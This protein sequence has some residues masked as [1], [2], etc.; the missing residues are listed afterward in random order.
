MTRW[1]DLRQ[2]L[3]Y[4]QQ[5]PQHSFQALQVES[6]GAIGF[7]LGRV[8]VDFHEHTIYARGHSGT[9]KQGDELRLAAGDGLAAGPDRGQ[10]HRVSRI[11]YHWG[12]FAHDGQRAH[13]HDEV[14]IAEGT[15]AFGEKY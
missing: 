13:I 11:E 9:G 2:R 10:L 12:E 1:T 8:V 6:V 5:L 7:G 4:R 15:A 14:V 3:S